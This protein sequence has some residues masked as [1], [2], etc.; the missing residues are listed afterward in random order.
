VIAENKPNDIWAIYLISGIILPILF[1]A[2][3]WA[4]VEV[5]NW[6][7]FSL[8]SE[9][10]DFFKR[11]YLATEP[12]GTTSANNYLFSV[13]ALFIFVPLIVAYELLVS[14]R[15]LRVLSQTKLQLVLSLPLVLLCFFLLFYFEFTLHG[16][17]NVG[18]GS[19]LIGPVFPVLVGIY[20]P[21]MSFTISNLM[22][23]GIKAMFRK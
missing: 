9:N 13:I 6:R 3:N 1:Y 20:I 5:E 8:I 2:A 11:R 21:W 10:V 16:K 23:L 18:K 19:I 14:G 22:K 15:G 7:L 4:G 12:Y 17:R